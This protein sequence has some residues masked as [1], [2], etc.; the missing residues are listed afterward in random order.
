MNESSKIK[1]PFTEEQI[2][3]LNIQ[4]NSGRVHPYTCGNVDCRAILIATEEG[5]ICPNC[6]YKQNWAFNIIII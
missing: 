3:K 4:Q 5:W 1:T 2:K 6:D